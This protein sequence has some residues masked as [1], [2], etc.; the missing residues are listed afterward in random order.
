MH[1]VPRSVLNT[2]LTALAR[3]LVALHQHMRS[4]SNKQIKCEAEM[5]KN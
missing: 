5:A 4:E 2:Y 3:R 1:H